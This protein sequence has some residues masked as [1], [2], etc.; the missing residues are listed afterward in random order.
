MWPSFLVSAALFAIVCRTAAAFTP[1]VHNAK[2]PRKRGIANKAKGGGFGSQ[3]P[4]A[5]KKQKKSKPSPIDT[6]ATT[7]AKSDAIRRALLGMDALQSPSLL[8]DNADLN[9]LLEASAKLCVG[10]S[11]VS[12]DAGMGLFLA[13]NAKAIDEGDIVTFYAVHGLGY[14]CD[15]GDGD[16]SSLFFSS[17]DES[18]INGECGDYV[19][20]LLGSRPLL[21]TPSGHPVNF[22][23]GCHLIVNTDPN[24]DRIPGWLGHMINDGAAMR[25]GS[26]EQDILRYYQDTSFAR[27]IVLVPFGMAPLV[28]A[29][30]TRRIAPGEE[31]LTSYGCQFWLEAQMKK[32]M[33]IG[34]DGITDNVL[35]EAR[36]V[37]MEV[38]TG[39]KSA[40]LTY[41]E[42][43]GRALGSVFAA[44][45]DKM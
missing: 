36:K 11:T 26:T 40:A 37:A 39:A 38:M 14:D 41:G 24:R 6:N 43:E 34:E 2:S 13:E 45:R 23:E 44:A 16:S 18:N 21:S 25:N 20:N 29:V 5:R 27:N 12:A 7:K 42:V 35:R 8:G 28:A 30:A 10:Q 31:L 22:G 17:K 3:P 32:G 4:V 15:D 19:L 33:D 9:R 1:V